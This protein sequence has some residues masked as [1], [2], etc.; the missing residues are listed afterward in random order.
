MAPPQARGKEALPR[1]KRR[2]ETPRQ[3]RRPHPLAT[4]E[5]TTPMSTRATAHLIG[6]L[7]NPRLRHTPNGYPVLELTL[8]GDAPTADGQKTLPYYVGVTVLGKYATFLEPVL[9]E[10]APTSVLGDLHQDRWTDQ[11]GQQKS[12]TRLTAHSLVM[13]DGP[14]QTREDARGQ[15]RLIGARNEILIV[16]NLTRDTET[17]RTPNGHLITRLSLAT[18]TRRGSGETTNY[19]TATAWHQ[20]AARAS[21]LH[22]GDLILLEGRITN[23]NWLDAKGNRRYT[24]RID[25]SRID[26]IHRPSKPEEPTTAPPP[27]QDPQGHEKAIN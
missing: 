21:D 22:K 19:F 11:N 18:N 10:G 15:K 24:C 14:H 16:G 23:E 12:V 26:P 3:E 5:G 6:C 25:T 13:L 9:K 20:L 1:K 8:A 27:H 2:N 17:R 4:R 7:N